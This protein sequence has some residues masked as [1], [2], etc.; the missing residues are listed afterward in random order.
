MAI[1]REVETSDVPFRKPFRLSI[2]QR[3]SPE[4][5]KYDVVVHGR[6][7]HER[8]RCSDLHRR[9]ILTRKVAAI[10]DDPSNKK[11]LFWPPPG[12]SLEQA[13]AALVVADGSVGVIGGTRHKREM[14]GDIAF[15]YPTACSVPGTFSL[16]AR[17]I[18]PARRLA[19]E[20]SACAA[21]CGPIRRCRTRAARACP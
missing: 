7:S 17:L 14:N 11:A 3:L 5:C 6:H 9:F 13:M 15:L 10:A 8:Q 4:C 20:I 16:E 2:C 18:R 21:Y 1:P 12:A 19:L